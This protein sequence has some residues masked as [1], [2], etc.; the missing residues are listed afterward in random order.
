M[1][2]RATIVAFLG[3]FMIKVSGKRL[4]GK[5]TAFDILNWIIL[6]SLFSRIITADA[7]FWSTLLTIFFLMLLHRLFAVISFHYDLLGTFLK[8]DKVILVEDGNIL[9]D[10][11]KGSQISEKDLRE[12]LR[13]RGSA[14]DLEK[15]EKAFLERSGDISIIEKNKK[16]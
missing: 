3:L 5:S 2:I 8:G 16:S 6:G 14:D 9:W 10:N 11:M 13:L 7:P 12:A 15:I 4:F 1:L